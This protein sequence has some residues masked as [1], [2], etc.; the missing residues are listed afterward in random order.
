[1]QNRAPAGSLAWQLGHTRS[2]TPTGSPQRLQN[3]ASGESG[4][5]QL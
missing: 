1:M 4:A 2:T 3:F 5:S